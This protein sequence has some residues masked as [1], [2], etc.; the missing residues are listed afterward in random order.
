[1]H[2][3]SP[4]VVVQD[5]YTALSIDPQFAPTWGH[6]RMRVL[7]GSTHMDCRELLLT[8][9]L[10]VSK[11]HLC[12]ELLFTPSFLER[13]MHWHGPGAV[14]QDFYTAI[15]IDPQFAPTAKLLL[16]AFKMAE[17]TSLATLHTGTLQAQMLARTQAVSQLSSGLVDQTFK[18]WW[19]AQV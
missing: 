16:Q 12:R 17:G 13:K 11:M 5:L 10:R 14:V 2:W 9:S 8:P 4:G 18:D 1:M 19:Q 15:S 3:H 7:H 6:R